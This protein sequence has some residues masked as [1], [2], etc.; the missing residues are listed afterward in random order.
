ME[1]L[2]AKRV[3]VFGPAGA[4][5]TWPAEAT[6]LFREERAPGVFIVEHESDLD[7]P[8]IE[9]ANYVY[10]SGQLMARAI[11]TNPGLSDKLT[12]RLIND[13]KTDGVL[14]FFARQLYLKIT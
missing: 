9:T 8:E 14:P 3:T 2:G 7:K 5:N 1:T 13:R 12:K 10:V 11:N 4:R 6:K